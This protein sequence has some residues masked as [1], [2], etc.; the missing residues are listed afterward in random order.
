MERLTIWGRTIH[1]QRTLQRITAADLCARMSISEATLRRM[2]QGDPGTGVGAFLSALLILGVMEE[3]APALPASL[4][5]DPPGRRVRRRGQ[6]K[7]Q[8]GKQ[9]DVQDGVPTPDGAD[10]DYF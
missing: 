2:E 9:R 3:A 5:S 6:E 7:S 10:A 8:D 4:W 1:A